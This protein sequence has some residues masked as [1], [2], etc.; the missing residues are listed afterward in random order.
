MP[1][2]LLSFW[3]CGE[4]GEITGKAAHDRLNRGDILLLICL[5]RVDIVLVISSDKIFLP[6]S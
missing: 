6:E 4:F 3:S 1:H 2:E 5:K